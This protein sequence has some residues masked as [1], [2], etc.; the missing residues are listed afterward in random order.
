MGAMNS[1]LRRLAKK[2]RE[3]LPLLRAWVEAQQELQA[4]KD[5]K[6]SKPNTETFMRTLAAFRKKTGSPLSPIDAQKLDGVSGIGDPSRST[7]I[8]WFKFAR[9][10]REYSYTN[11][12][13][14]W[15]L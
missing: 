5:L 15:T 7:T 13:L 10:A 3:R 6:P 4:R 8:Q 14:G 9:R 1:Y 2:R 11:T 12:N